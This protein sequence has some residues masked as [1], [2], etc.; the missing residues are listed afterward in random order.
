M[1]KSDDFYNALRDSQPLAFLASLSIA[2]AVLSGDKIAE[3]HNHAIIAGSMFIFSFIISMFSKTIVTS[4]GELKQYVNW[5]RNFFLIIGIG[6]L[7]LTVLDFSKNLPQII[8]FVFA[9]IFLAG[10]LSFILPMRDI[11]NKSKKEHGGKLAGE[12]KPRLIVV[13][14]MIGMLMLASGLFFFL[15]L[16]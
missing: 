6:Y 10:A 7:T 4:K 11:V 9:W 13:S 3:I 15:A 16:A 1:E 5:T 14:V 12:E 2:I 8:R